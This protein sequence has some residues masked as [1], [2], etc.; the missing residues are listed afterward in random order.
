ME[1]NGPEEPGKDREGT[2]QYPIRGTGKSTGKKGT[3]EQDR[4]QEC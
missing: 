2:V 1:E 3:G 4:G